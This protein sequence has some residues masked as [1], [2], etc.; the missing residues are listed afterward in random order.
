MR[1]LL[2]AAVG[3]LL[4]VPAIAVND[5]MHGRPRYEKIDEKE[6]IFYLT[7]NGTDWYLQPRVDVEG[8]IVKTLIR[9]VSPGVDSHGLL[10]VNCKKKDYSAYHEAWARIPTSS[11]LINRIYKE[12]CNLKV[13]Y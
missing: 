7:E 8:E 10:Q 2:L 5:P 12:F 6:W 3:V 11:I 4:A 1:Q 13:A 9:S